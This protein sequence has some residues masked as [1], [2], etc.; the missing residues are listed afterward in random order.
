MF[1]LKNLFNFRGKS[2]GDNGEKPF[3]AHLEDLRDMLVRIVLTLVLSTVLCYI[4]RAELMD[5]LRRPIEKVWVT[6]QEAKLPEGISTTKWE[7]AKKAARDTSPLSPTQRKHFFAQ[8]DDEELQHYAECATYYRTALV[9]K[10]KD[11]QKNFIKTL[12][13][14]DDKTRSTIIELLDKN[15]NAKVDARNN[16]VYMRSLRPAE[17]FML[18]FKLAFFAGV[19][20]SFPLLMFFILQFVL[21]G[22]KEK[23]RKALWPA[24]TIGFGLFL[25]G[26]VFCY[27]FVLP[28]TLD[29]FYS[30][31]QS[32]GVENEW[33]IG[34]YISFVTQFTLIFGLAFELPVVVMTL[35]K[36]G[37]LSYETMR[38]TRGYAV[39]TIVIVA[40][41]ITPTGDALTLGMLAIPMIILYEICIWLAYFSRKKEIA[42][43]EAELE[44]IRAPRIATVPGIVDTNDDEEDNGESDEFQEAEDSDIYGDDE[45][46]HEVGDDDYQHSDYHDRREGEYIDHGNDSTEDEGDEEDDGILEEFPDDGSEEKVDHI[47]G[48]DGDID[49]NPGASFDAEKPKS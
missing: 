31:S 13:E 1:L 44:T 2:H 7:L 39:L 22:L 24:L 38:N 19:I 11:K 5:L 26:V 4:F 32:L 17:T 42:E 6:S 12:P 48:E 25:L 30:Y 41:V 40:A 16:V 37:L 20:V 49:F 47:D 9:L 28:K 27:Y 8:F 35:V 23:E 33:R 34:D 29:F 18:S 15:P 43:E 14:I 21:P 36:I 3:M 10:D 45:E 46:Y